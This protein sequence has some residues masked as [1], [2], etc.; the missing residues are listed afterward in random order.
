MF[1]STTRLITALIAAGGLTAPVVA[2]ADTELWSGDGAA[3]PI[4]AGDKHLA[5]SSYDRATKRYTLMIGDR[6][7]TPVTIR[8]AEVATSSRPFDVSI[9][10]LG[11][12]AV[13]VYSRC[14][15]GERACDIYRYPL[16][17]GREAKLGAASSRL[18]DE[19][20]A[21]LTDKGQVVFVRRATRRVTTGFRSRTAI[22]RVQCDGVYVRSLKDSAPPQRLDL[23]LCGEVSALATS[24]SKVA[25]ILVGDPV[26]N[27]STTLAV[28]RLRGGI[29]KVR[30]RASA[31][32]DG[33]SPYAAVAF[34]RYTVIA[35]QVGNRPGLASGFLRYP[36][37]AG[38]PV[39]SPN[40]NLVGP[41]AIDGDAI[42]HFS[43]RPGSDG[44]GPTAPGVC[45]AGSDAILSAPGTPEDQIVRGE[46]PCRLV[47]STGLPTS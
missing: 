47:Q 9:G 17:G 30:G 20:H 43:G 25:V 46:A 3:T 22:T 33:F 7:S 4:A 13:V 36:I 14:A 10:K 12:K 42:F 5:F 18:H 38:N 39:P 26:S 24:G 35:S 32:Q 41:F 15:D 11:G 44:Y 19:A 34:L 21:A 27:P 31:G 40:P 45:G 8:A 6:T 28:L 37:P 1:A 16:A 2:H 29:A 23:P